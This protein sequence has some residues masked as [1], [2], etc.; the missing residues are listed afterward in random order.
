MNCNNS[1]LITNM[2]NI[3]FSK[4]DMIILKNLVD[5]KFVRYNSKLPAKGASLVNYLFNY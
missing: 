2:N 5:V 3:K 1:Y 4:M